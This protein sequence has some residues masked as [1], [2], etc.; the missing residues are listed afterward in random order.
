M[1]LYLKSSLCNQTLFKR[2]ISGLTEL[3]LECDITNGGRTENEL[4][5]MAHSPSNC[6]LCKHKVNVIIVSLFS[7]R[8]AVHQPENYDIS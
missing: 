8:L 2:H 3:K 5:S 1:W 6:L 4:L 7:S